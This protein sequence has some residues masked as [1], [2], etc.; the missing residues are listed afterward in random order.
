L[1]EIGR[2]APY[3]HDGSL[4]TLAAV[5]DHYNSGGVARESRSEFVKPLGLTMQEKD[6]L[7]AFMQTLTS[8]MDPTLIPVLP[9]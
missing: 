7:A 1:R 5:V 8:D 2:R 4:P 6:D 3:M 9:R